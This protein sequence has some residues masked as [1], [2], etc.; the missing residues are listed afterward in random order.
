MIN[1][2]RLKDRW[3]NVSL[4]SDSSGEASLPMLLKKH[5]SSQFGDFFQGQPSENEFG[6]FFQFFRDEPIM[7]CPERWEKTPYP[8]LSNLKLILGVGDKT[9]AKLK[10]S[11]IQSIHDLMSHP[12]YGE[13]SLQFHQALENETLS[14]MLSYCR[15]RLGYNHPDLL[16]LST[17]HPFEHLCFLDIETLGLFNCPLFLIGLARWDGKNIHITQYLAPDMMSEK[18]VLSA[19][20]KEIPHGSVLI[21]YNG[22]SFDIPFINDRLRLYQLPSIPRSPSYDMLLYAR[23]QWRHRLP[24]CRLQT[25]E[26]SILGRRRKDDVPGSLVP[27]YYKAYLSHQNVGPLIPILEHNQLDLISLMEIYFTMLQ[28]RQPKFGTRDSPLYQK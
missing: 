20:Q 23:G 27:T 28:S 16:Y 14:V 24:D 15:S 17:Y 21:T 11:G 7:Q 25:V 9:N 12:R 6:T 1:F 26:S 19:C 22:N 4:S 18:A 2:T 8:L 13:A 5:Q 10:E 3:R